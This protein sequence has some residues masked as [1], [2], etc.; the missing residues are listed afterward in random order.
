M[1]KTFGIPTG[2]N[3]LSG[4]QGGNNG[5]NFKP[6]LAGK[7]G[8]YI[9]IANYPALFAT[10]HA[11]IMNNGNC[12]GNCFYNPNGGVYYIDFWELEQ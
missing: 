10:G 6:L 7:K 9:M 1:R 3:H 11:D 8:I 2:D 4:S 12:P 5:E